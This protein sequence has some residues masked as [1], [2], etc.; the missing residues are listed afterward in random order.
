MKRV[1]IIGGGGQARVVVDAIEAAGCATVLGL[2]TDGGTVIDCGYPVLG[3]DDDLATLWQEHGPFDLAVAIGDGRIR[4]RIVNKL[5]GRLPD[6]NY[7]TVVHPGANLAGRVKLGQ[8]AFIAI[9]ATVSVRATVGD[10][11]L[12]NTNA[13]VDHDCVIG[14]FSSIAPNVALGGMVCIGDE[15]LIGIGATVLPGVTIGAGATVAAGAVV[16]RNVAAGS[17]VMGVPARAVS[18]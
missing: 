2:V 13:S 3:H 10:H 9:G 15:A 16:T 14:A 5:L 7:L 4:R 6:M 11:A 8:G 1:V 17:L 18:T 12:I